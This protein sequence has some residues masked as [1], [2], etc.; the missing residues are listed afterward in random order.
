[1]AGEDVVGEDDC[2][3]GVVQPP[4]LAGGAVPI[5]ARAAAC[6]VAALGLVAG[7]DVVGQGEGARVEDAAALP[8]GG[9]GAEGDGARALGQAVR[10]GQAG[11]GHRVP[12]GDV[13]DLG[14]V[15]P[16]DGELVGAEAL[17]GQVLG[18]RQRAVDRVE[19]DDLTG[20]AGCE[21]DG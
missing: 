16:R 4:A 14:G 20:Q 6:A 1:V 9:G 7:H 12:G 3:P 21:V 13:E 19:G 10:D 17:D 15:G 11:D 18:D 8:H 2:P 5:H